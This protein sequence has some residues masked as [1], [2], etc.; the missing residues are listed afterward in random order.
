MRFKRAQI[1]WFNQYCAY[2]AIR[3]DSHF[4]GSFV[5]IGQTGYKKLNRKTL[6]S[7]FMQDPLPAGRRDLSVYKRQYSYSRRASLHIIAHR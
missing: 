2:S 5:Q 7:N 4:P 1:F 6:K 3:I